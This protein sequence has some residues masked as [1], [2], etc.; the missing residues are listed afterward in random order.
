MTNDV[1]S[2]VDANRTDEYGATDPEPE[3]TGHATG[4][5]IV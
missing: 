2:S 5:A 1:V 4:S 3:A